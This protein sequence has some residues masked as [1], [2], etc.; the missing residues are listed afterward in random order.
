[1]PDSLLDYQR[2]GYRLLYH[3]PDFDSTAQVWRTVVRNYLAR[4]TAD[5]KVVLVLQLP[6]PEIPPALCALARRCSPPSPPAIHWLSG[7]AYSVA[8]LRAADRF[9]TT[10]E[11]VCSECLDH[12][13]DGAE[14]RYGLD[15]WR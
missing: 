7:S 12:L 3:I 10:K 14:I 1:M 11:A 15:L 5:D 6:S 13:R 8:A 4:H 2:R 9:I